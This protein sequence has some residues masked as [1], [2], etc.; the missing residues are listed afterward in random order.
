MYIKKIQQ[1]T[2][3]SVCYHQILQ[4][5]PQPYNQILKNIDEKKK[6]EII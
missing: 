5:P 1:E 6:D 2:Q 3:Q 4:C